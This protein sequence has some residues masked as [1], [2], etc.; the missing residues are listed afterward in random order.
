MSSLEKRLCYKGYDAP[1]TNS[2]HNQEGTGRP[3]HFNDGSDDSLTNNEM[4]NMRQVV[5]GGPSTA[6]CAAAEMACSKAAAS[7]V[8]PVTPALI[9]WPTWPV[10]EDPTVQGYLSACQKQGREPNPQHW[11]HTCALTDLHLR[12][13]MAEQESHYQ[14]EHGVYR[15]VEKAREAAAK[16]KKGQ[17]LESPVIYDNTAPEDIWKMIIAWWCNPN[18]VPPTVHEDPN[19]HKLNICDID[20]TLWVKAI[21]P[22]NK[23]EFRRFQ[24]FMFEVLSPTNGT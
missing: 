11:W 23:K 12:K 20:I 21:V 3:F 13:V 2:D 18:G 16:M 10:E 24:D 1:E 19:T 15:H 7:G 8:P 17:R 5:E 14:E 22:S 4:P 9:T 6:E